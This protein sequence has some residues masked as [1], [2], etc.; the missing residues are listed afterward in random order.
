M[1]VDTK[2]MRERIARDKKRYDTG[3]FC[4]KK[5]DLLCDI[6]QSKWNVYKL[7]NL[8]WTYD[9]DEKYS[10]WYDEF[11]EWCKNYNDTSND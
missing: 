5:S 3:N 1:S 2:K 4:G 11:T 7:E 10:I 6:A 9:D 8:D